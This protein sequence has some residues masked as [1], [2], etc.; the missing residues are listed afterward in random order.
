MAEDL[1]VEIEEEEKNTGLMFILMRL[2]RPALLV[3]SKGWGGG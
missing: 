3:I 2:P 1:W